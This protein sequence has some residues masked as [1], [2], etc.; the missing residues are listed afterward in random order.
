V[1]SVGEGVTSVKPGDKVIPCYTPECKESECIFCMSPKTNLCPKI[2]STQGQGVMPDGTSR[3]R[4]NGQPIFHF[5]G[6]SSFSE[7]TVVAEI[8]CAK[9]SDDA[10]LEEVRFCCATL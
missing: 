5:M 9:I 8:S 3:F 7:Y 4:I 10:S 1:E 6:C 2:R